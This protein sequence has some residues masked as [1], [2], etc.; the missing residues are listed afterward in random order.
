MDAGAAD[1][2]EVEAM[3]EV[4]GALR[5]K[6]SLAVDGVGS[7]SD[8]DVTSGI[9]VGVAVIIDDDDEEMYP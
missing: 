9:V 8:I 7:T 2:L 5:N 3:T 1:M 6:L 4:V